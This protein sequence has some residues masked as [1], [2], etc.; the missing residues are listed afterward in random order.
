MKLLIVHY[1]SLS[2]YF[3][4]L[5]SKYSPR[6]TAANTLN[7]CP[8]LTNS[9]FVIS[10]ILALHNKKFTFQRKCTGV[11]SKINCF[12]LDYMQ[13]VFCFEALCNLSKTTKLSACYVH[14]ELYGEIYSDSTGKRPL[15]VVN[16]DV[17]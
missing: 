14:D 13:P 6:I 11:I 2:C 15:T 4:I 17:S 9:I 16:F 7:L 10:I 5:V 8:P 3:L 12:F 1:V